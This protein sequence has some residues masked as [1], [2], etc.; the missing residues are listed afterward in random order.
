IATGEIL[1]IPHSTTTWR[2]A[3]HHGNILGHYILERRFC[4][5]GDFANEQNKTLLMSF[6]ELYFACLPNILNGWNIEPSQFDNNLSIVV[7]QLRKPVSKQ[8][9]VNMRI[10]SLLN[11]TD[12]KFIALGT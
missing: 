12:F 7:K 3:D 6:N 4:E 1:E 11:A 10:A 9:A 5:Q 2:F 8:M